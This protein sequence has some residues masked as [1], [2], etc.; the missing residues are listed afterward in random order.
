MGVFLRMRYT[1]TLVIITDDDDD[2]DYPQKEQGSADQ[3]RMCSCPCPTGHVCHGRIATTGWPIHKQDAKQFKTY[4]S[5]RDLHADTTTNTANDHSRSDGRG[6][7]MLV[8]KQCWV[9]FYWSNHVYSRELL[10]K[11]PYPPVYGFH[12]YP[13]AHFSC[14]QHNHV[15]RCHYCHY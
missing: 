11:W 1:H 15:D 5:L 9:D 14:F 7:S 12:E 13:H 10:L 8:E 3:R 2:D 4:D 6:L